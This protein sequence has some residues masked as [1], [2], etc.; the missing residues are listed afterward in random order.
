MMNIIKADIYRIVR[1]K[2]IYITFAVL[3]ALNIL[4][5]ATMNQGTIGAAMGELDGSLGYDHES[6]RFDG[7]NIAEVLYTSTDN[8]A[9]FLLP[10]FILVASH[11]FTHGTVKNSLSR[12][13]SRTKLYIS[14][15]LLSSCLTLLMLIFYIASGIV[16]ATILRGYGGTPPDGYWLHIIKVCSAQFAMLLALNCVGI[17]LIFSTKRTAIVNSVYIAFCLVPAIVVMSLINVNPDFIKIYDFDL[18]GNM[19]KLGFIN[20]LET[21]DFV[22]A[23]ATAAF[24]IAAPTLAGIALF[25]RAEIK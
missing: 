18:L 14:K 25:K 21:A 10:I 4:V 13:I 16:I 19:R 9:Y 12:G 7:I 2:A 3:L 22:K 15:L 24:Y 1:G 8:T 23:F 6:F 17:F 5:V 20:A 11:M